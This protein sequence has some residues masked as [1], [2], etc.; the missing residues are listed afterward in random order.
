MP[1]SPKVILSH[2]RHNGCIAEKEYEKLYQAVD[3]ITRWI[4]CSERLPNRDECIKDNGLFIVSDG[5]RG[6]S[7]WFDIYDTQMF[8]E[9]TMTGFRVDR[10]VTAWMPLPKPYE[11]KAW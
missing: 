1:R 9:P 5:N 3:T 2:L 10:A 8:G 11:S 6:Y 4:P 7:E